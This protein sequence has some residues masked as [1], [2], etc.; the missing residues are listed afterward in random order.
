MDTSRKSYVEEKRRG[1]SGKW[2]AEVDMYRSIAER[3]V[4][5]RVFLNGW[6]EFWGPAGCGLERRGE[7]RRGGDEQFSRVHL[8]TTEELV[9]STCLV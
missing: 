8:N 1:E 2:K 9:S 6:E 3:R 7:R 4:F 5:G